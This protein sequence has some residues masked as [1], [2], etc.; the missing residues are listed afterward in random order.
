[1][2]MKSDN[3]ISSVVTNI[4]KIKKLATIRAD[5]VEVFIWWYTTKQM[6]TS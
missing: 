2:F 6:I 4:G 1:M 5:C 3:V